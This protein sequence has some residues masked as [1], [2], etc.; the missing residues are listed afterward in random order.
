MPNLAKVMKLEISRLARKETRNVTSKLQ[1]E[2]VALKK[3]LAQQKVQIGQLQRSGKDILAQL[4]KEK[5]VPE[6][7]PDAASKFRILGKGI[8]SMRKRLGLSQQEFGKLIGVTDVCVWLWE[9]KHGVLR[10]LAGD[11]RAKLMWAKGLRA[12]EAKRLLEEMPKKDAG[13][14]KKAPAKATRT[15]RTAKKGKR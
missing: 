7:P 15:R 3:R 12:A 6:I 11:S 10:R 1:K 4:P 2:V 5:P 9:K 8:R 14:T 13:K